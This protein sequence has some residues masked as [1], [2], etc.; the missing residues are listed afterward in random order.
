MRTLKQSRSGFSLVEV[1]VVLV[2]L[3][4]GIFAIARLFP[5]GFGSIR[6]T[7]RV[8]IAQSL[9]RAAGEFL[10]A[11]ASNLPDGIVALRPLSDG[12]MVPD[13]T[14]NPDPTFLFNEGNLN[15]PIVDSRI[16]GPNRWRRVLGEA[17]RIPPPTTTGYVTTGPVSL[18]TLNF[19]PFYADYGPTPNHEIGLKWQSAGLQVY[20]ATP[21]RRIVISNVPPDA[22]DTKTMREDLAA[23]G[24]DYE[25][26]RIYFPAVPA[27]STDPI[28]NDTRDFKVD[29]SY[30]QIDPNNMARARASTTITIT[31]IPWKELVAGRGYNFVDLPV[32]P[33]DAPAGTIAKYEP[34]AEFVY[35]KFR[36]LDGNIPFSGLNPYQYKVMNPLTGVIGFNPLAATA[37]LRTGSGQGITAKIDY[38]VED[39]QL[40]HEDMVIPSDLQPTVK[41]AASPIKRLGDQ[42]D[43]LNYI[44][45]SNGANQGESLEYRGLIRAY[46]SFPGR[47]G[48]VGRP[49]PTDNAVDFVVA[50]LQEGLYLTNQSFGVAP[51]PPGQ[52]GLI[53]YR[54]GTIRFNDTVA[55]IAPGGGVLSP[56]PI[57]GKNIRVYYRAS[58]DWGVAA[59]KPF[60]NYLRQSVDLNN[61]AVN[62]YMQGTGGYIFLPMT[63]L[64]K[65]VMIDYIWRTPDTAPAPPGESLPPIE[66]TVLGELHRV[67][68]PYATGSPVSNAGWVLLNNGTCQGIAGCSVTILGVRGASVS[69][70]AYWQEGNNWRF[71]DAPAILTRD[72]RDRASDGE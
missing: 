44:V 47:N 38:D 27:N 28:F 21:L 3:V 56:Q 33:P 7:E 70:R 4:I 54:A 31:G 57:A 37:P 22:D 41:V 24:I 71:L 25:L 60:S 66:R 1:L 40:L 63:D 2:V 53:D 34:E 59:M 65:S 64:G 39:W 35:Q 50:D 58:A 36:Y 62:E 43:V 10:R 30:Q 67:N 48:D 13:P 8:T 19:S 68:E 16:A 52:N 69:S 6:Y 72:T 32:A 61:L 12:T 26:R 17:V 29:F 20:G 42:E 51:G 23:Y 49:S 9:T 55:W 15:T 46:P 18:Y 14:L 5:Q 45:G 11:H